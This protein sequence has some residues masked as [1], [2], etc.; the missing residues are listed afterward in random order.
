MICVWN[1][2]D[3]SPSVPSLF[4]VNRSE[5][6]KA[7]KW[8]NVVEYLCAKAVDETARIQ[9]VYEDGGRTCFQPLMTPTQ[10]MWWLN[11]DYI[12]NSQHLKYCT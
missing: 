3:K 2:V 9:V 6:L 12:I 11:L 7:S 5:I 10:I 4:F 1:R 8:L